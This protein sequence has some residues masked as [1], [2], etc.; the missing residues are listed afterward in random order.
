MRSVLEKQVALVVTLII[1]FVG[2]SGCNENISTQ[3][4]I[5]ERLIGTWK[6]GESVTFIFF[7]DGM[8][9]Y[10]YGAPATYSIKDENL[11]IIVEGGAILTFDYSFSNNDNALHLTY[12]NIGTEFN[13]IKQ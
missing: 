12:I 13:L 11:V 5:D 1:L 3:S 2:L 8:C 9:S 10:L 6:Q 7:S 4:Y